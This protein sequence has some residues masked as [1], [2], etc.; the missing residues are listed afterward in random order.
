VILC[1]TRTINPNGQQNLS[2]GA[3]R[4][5]HRRADH[6]FRRRRTLGLAETCAG[7]QGLPVNHRRPGRQRGDPP[8]LVQIDHFKGGVSRHQAPCSTTSNKSIGCA[9]LGPNTTTVSYGP[10]ETGIGK[11]LRGK[12]AHR[13]D[14]NG[15]SGEDFTAEG[16]YKGPAAN[17]AEEGPEISA[18]FA[19]NDLMGNRFCCEFAAGAM[20]F[21]SPHQTLG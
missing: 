5:T 13:F 10:L 19:S 7:S 3:S 11:A 14:P 20:A 9:S 16:G 17:P 15:L 1:V 6:L 12:L 4:K 2:S 18:V 8:T 21:A